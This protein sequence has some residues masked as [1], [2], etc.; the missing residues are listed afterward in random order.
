MKKSVTIIGAGLGGLTAG[1]LLSEEGYSVT[2]LEQH[3]VVGGCATTFKRKGGY[4]CEVGLHE[5]EGVYSNPSLRKIFT[6]LKVYDHVTFVK[7]REFF[8]VTSAR[9]TFV[10]P[11]GIREALDKLT[12]KFPEEKAGIKKYFRLIGKIS[13]EL[14]RLQD[15]SWYHYLLFPLYF[16][17]LLTY[18]NRTVMEVLDGL[19]DN[20]ELKLI[21]NAN[22]Q[23][24]NDT[25]ETLSFLLHS[26]AQHSYYRGGGWFVRGGSQKLSDHF[27]NVIRANGGKIVTGATVVS[28]R[29]EAVEYKLKKE[30]CRIESDAIVSNLS[31]RQTYDLF[32][33]P[34]REKR[35]VSDSLCTI[36][37]G[38]RKNLKGVYG[39]RPYSNFLFD[40]VASVPEYTAML[41]QEISARGFVF[42]D[43][44]QLDSNLTKDAD[45]SFG[46]VCMTDRI[47]E[48]A[49]LGEEKYRQKKEEL[50][51]RVLSKLERHYPK[52]SDLVEYAEVGTAKTVARYIKTPRGTAYGFRP[53]PRQFFR[54][55][56]V[57]SDRIDRLYFVGQ[58]VI[59]GGFSPAILSG[60]LCCKAIL[61][62][63]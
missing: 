27:A 38:F 40:D 20:E 9:G 54:I 55:P 1:A 58:W 41:H 53:T 14:M 30:Y 4:L 51:R 57:K 13:R 34:Y 50:I 48:W 39:T 42:V 6:K 21:L 19:L 62:E 29:P 23:Y 56:S 22:V 49:Q 35:E 2:L 17:T 32:K 18:R 11:E 25:P 37:F 52:I 10:M 31:P 5:M 7:P 45:K 28:C 12:E 3:N 59:S 33:S 16:S 43:Y 60:D 26:V 44:S 47:E 8:A 63:V 46:A 15:A 36:Y 24:Y 61:K